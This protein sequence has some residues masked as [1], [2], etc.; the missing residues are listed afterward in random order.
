MSDVHLS[1][2]QAAFEKKDYVTAAAE[3]HEANRVW[4]V[5][6]QRQSTYRRIL[7]RF[8]Q[9][10]VGVTS[11]GHKFPTRTA[12]ETR[13]YRLQAAR[14]FEP[15][16]A[17]SVAYYD[18]EFFEQWEPLDL[19][20]R[21]VFSLRQTQPSW[22]PVSDV[23]SP[24][25][26]DT[27]KARLDPKNPAYDERFASYIDSYSIRSPHEFEVKF[28]RIP[29]RVESLFDFPLTKA[30]GELYSQR[31]APRLAA[32]NG[33]ENI[34]TCDRRTGRTRGIAIPRCGSHRAQVPAP[35]RSRAGPAPKR[36][37]DGAGI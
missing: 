21:A 13:H 12:S 8:Q 32:E 10:H 15:S 23:T 30:N 3:A 33:P 26:I 27:F 31:F 18:T 29:L 16:R 14:L 1:K 20:R 36:S 25:I 5:T 6:G 2:A 34:P 19:G 17:D 28:T 22:Q 37:A 24:N 35:A 11:I 9:L 4:Q 7:T